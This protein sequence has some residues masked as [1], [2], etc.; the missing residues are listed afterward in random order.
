MFYGSLF[1]LL[2]LLGFYVR[3]DAQLINYPASFNTTSVIKYNGYNI[4]NTGGFYNVK[5]YGAKGDGITDDT[6][7]IQAALDADRKGIN[8]NGQN[9]Y[10]FPRP[11]TV[12]FPK[13]TYL[14]SGSLNWIGQSYDADGS[15]EG[16]NDY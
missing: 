15:R 2:S 1:Y 11:K 13:G 6:Q 7:A 8:T 3:V 14:I 9:D 4:E 10:F 5:N 12:Y 16:R